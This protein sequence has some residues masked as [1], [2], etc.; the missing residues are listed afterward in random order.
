M[1]KARQ[2][3]TNSRDKIMYDIIDKMCHLLPTSNLGTAQGLI[4]I[5]KTN[6]DIDVSYGFYTHSKS[7]FTY[8]DD[9][10]FRGIETINRALH[11]DKTDTIAELIGQLV[12]YDIDQVIFTLDESDDTTNARVSYYVETFNDERNDPEAEILYWRSLIDYQPETEDEIAK[13]AK[14]TTILEKNKETNSL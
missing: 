4:N 10:Y 7:K 9:N 8:F 3:M 5:I 6:K 12:D 14:L 13:V 11:H 2:G 1:Q